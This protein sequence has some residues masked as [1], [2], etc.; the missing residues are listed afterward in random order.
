LSTGVSTIDELDSLVDVAASHN[1]RVLYL[2]GGD[3][4]RKRDFFTSH[5]LVAMDGISN[6]NKTNN[7][8]RGLMEVDVATAAK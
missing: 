7:S 1:A 8:S 6:S 5:N 3:Q 4:P 2:K